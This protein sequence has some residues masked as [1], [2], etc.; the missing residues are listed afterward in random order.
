MQNYSQ[1]NFKQ[2][3]VYESHIFLFWYR[4]ITIWCSLVI[5]LCS[6]LRKAHSL[7]QYML[8]IILKKTNSQI[9]V[10]VCARARACLRACVCGAGG[11][12][13]HLSSRLKPSS[14]IQISLF[15]LHFTVSDFFETQSLFSRAKVHENILHIN[16]LIYDSAANMQLQHILQIPAGLETVQVGIHKTNHRTVLIPVESL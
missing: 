15:H 9:R 8:P 1:L 6:G 5:G 3:L 16:L 12:C 7:C 2:S 10:C 13:C 4:Y 11:S 14:T